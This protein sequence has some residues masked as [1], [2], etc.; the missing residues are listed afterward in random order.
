MKPAPAPLAES[1]STVLDANGNGAVTFGPNRQRQRWVP[2]L[3]VAVTTSSAVK[4]S[5]AQIWLGSTN[6]GG[7]YTGSQDSDDLPAVTLYQGQMLKVVWTGGDVGAV[8]TA[9]ITGTVEWW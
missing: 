7:T 8:A 9:S 3:T 4:V 2:P 5:Q 6:I 1:Y